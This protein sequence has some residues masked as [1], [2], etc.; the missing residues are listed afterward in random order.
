MHGLR[1]VDLCLEMASD[2]NYNFGFVVQEIFELGLTI[3][4]RGFGTLKKIRTLTPV[5]T[6]RELFLQKNEV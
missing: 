5:S 2:F 4:S 6:V 1:P 3:K